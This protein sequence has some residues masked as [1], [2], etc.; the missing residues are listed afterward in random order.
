MPIEELDHFDIFAIWSDTS[1]RFNALYRSRKIDLNLPYPNTNDHIAKY[2]FEDG[3][4]KFYLD[5]VLK[6]ETLVADNPAKTIWFGNPGNPNSNLVWTK[7]NIDYVRVKSISTQPNNIISLTSDWDS[8]KHQLPIDREANIKVKVSDNNGNPVPNSIISSSINNN[9]LGRIET[10]SDKTDVNGYAYFKFHP[11]L[12]GSAK[13]SFSNSYSNS[14][15]DF[16]IYSPPII[17][18]PCMGA[19]LNTT[20]FFSNNIDS[21]KW[22]WS[23]F[24]RSGW[25]EIYA[26]LEWNSY[27]E[28]VNYKTVFYDWRKT[29]NTSDY[30]TGTADSVSRFVSP[31]INEMLLNR[32]QGQKVNVISHSFGGLVTRSMLQNDQ[33]SGRINQFI[34]LGTPHSGASPAYYTWQ[35]G[36]VFPGGDPII[37]NSTNM[38][39]KAYQHK[40]GLGKIEIFQREFASIKNLLPIYEYLYSSAGVILN[41]QHEHQNNILKDS[42]KTYEFRD[43]VNAKNIKFHSFFSV[44]EPTL[45][46]IL[47]SSFPDGNY[48]MDGRPSKDQTLSSGDDVVL[49]K[50]ATITNLPKTEVQGS[51]ANL[52]NNSANEIAQLFRF[53]MIEG[54]Q[55]KNTKNVLTAMV[56]SPAYPEIMNSSGE[57]I[58]TGDEWIEAD[59]KN[60]YAS[61]LENGIYTV[62]V[63]GTDSGPFTVYIPFSGDNNSAE[64]EFRSVTA[65]NKVDYYDIFI[66]DSIDRN[67][68]SLLSTESRFHPSTRSWLKGKP[69]IKVT[70][71]IPQNF[72]PNQLNFSQ[73]WV[74]GHYIDILS[75]DI[76]KKSSKITLILDVEQLSSA[77]G[78]NQGQ[79]NIKTVLPGENVS[80]FGRNVLT[81]K[82]SELL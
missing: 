65:N 39:V 63:T 14:S 76:D 2:I 4:Y 49:P 38:L 45:D 80:L 36:E 60:A 29:L 64:F 67:T 43:V 42:M 23:P 25:D 79:V 78:S 75:H 9:I 12:F 34:T 74:N 51:H 70:Y 7:F 71:D 1:F 8:A 6:Y 77:L 55:I 53:N 35:G 44:G 62:R 66:D 21:T 52:P 47:V 37:S 72:D 48:W 61:N 54:R 73:L 17:I 26:L 40:N 33:D 16:N 19:S 11:S 68:T 58:S 5:G 20:E 56:L 31:A 10:V 27:Q 3:R 69:A 22:K 50:S 81:F 30:P 13:L 57:V 82:W 28:G 18:V 15:I 59:T 32:P 41:F 24:A 46:N